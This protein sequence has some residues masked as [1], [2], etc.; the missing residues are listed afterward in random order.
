MEKATDRPEGG[1]KG[2]EDEAS[3]PGVFK[4]KIDRT[5]MLTIRLRL[6]GATRATTSRS[7]LKAETT[8]YRR[9]RWETSDG[10]QLTAPLDPEI[11]GGRGP[12]LHPL[13]PMLHFQG[14]MAYEWMVALL[15]GMGQ[16]VRLLGTKL[17]SF[18]A[19]GRCGA[20]GGARRFNLRPS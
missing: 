4:L 18:R 6:A 17:E 12:H 5:V 16:V 15:N 19:R 7:D 9:G 8:L 2:S 1:A 10:K 13:V 20:A 3:R 11:V 14:Q